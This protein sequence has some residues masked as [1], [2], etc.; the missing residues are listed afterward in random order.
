LQRAAE[1]MGGE[2]ALAR[3]LGIAPSHLALWIRGVASPPDRVFLEAVDIV[4]ERE[5]PKAA[6]IANN[7]RPRP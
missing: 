2:E 3:H 6:Q 5:I 4:L 7:V 1:I